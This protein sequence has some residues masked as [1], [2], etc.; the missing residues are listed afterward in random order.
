M[1]RALRAIIEYGLR[2][3][4]TS[5]AGF[6]LSRRQVLKLGAG[7]AAAAALP[8]V[9]GGCAPRQR[10]GDD[11][12]PAPT[13]QRV[14]VIGAGFAGLAC[15]D[16][17]A[18]GGADVT[19]L[20]ASARPGGRVVT[21]RRM[22]PGDGVELGG[23]WIGKNHPTWLA[24]ARKF[25]LEL[26]EPEGAPEDAEEPVILG[27]ERLSADETAALFE[28][29]DG[30]LAKLI[31]MARPVDPVRPYTLGNAEEL[32]RR[33]FADFVA[34]SGLTDRAQ[35]LLIVGEETDN[36]V[37][38]E[39]M[40]LLAYL[41]MIAGGG[42]EA[43][44]TDSEW[45]RAARGN[46][47]LATALAK[48]LGGRVRF[49]TPALSIQRYPT[50]AIVSTG[51]GERIEC[52]AVVLAV[53]P[54]VWHRVRIEP[55]LE[56]AF[57]P[58]MGNNVKL[59]LTLSDPVWLRDN[60]KDEVQT[61]GL[62]GLTWAATAPQQGKPVA[63]TLFSGAA[64][65]QRLRELDPMDRPRQAIASIAPAYPGLSDAV[66]AHRFVD[67]PGMPLVQASYSFPAPGQVTAFG[68][69]LTDG[70]RDT[71][72]PLMFAGEHASYGFTGYM[73][74]ALSSGVRVARELIRAAK[75]VP[76]GA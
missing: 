6:T 8:P 50:G 30:A 53:P 23:E 65:S 19:V 66:T 67:W 16:T 26:E 25:D 49:N 10:K 43:Y 21:D 39:R 18:D 46:D 44:Y 59:I 58:Q 74:G 17:L 56:D 62:V 37:P 34:G 24:Y 55:P 68:P 27:G 64:A 5:K 52:D 73:E 36:G 31:E 28:E 9:L 41:S 14:V 47:A 15:A 1:P 35:R 13:G 57:H 51:R 42:F 60:L 48:K 7:A 54:S 61:D 4:M 63:L 72:A 70:V 29:I 2:H 69:T 20:E 76:V 40:S 3:G 45:Y 38:A 71:R 12:K 75:A 11:N 32:D 33:S 22:I